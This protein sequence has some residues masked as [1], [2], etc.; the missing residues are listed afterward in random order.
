MIKKASRYNININIQ[1]SSSMSK[2]EKIEPQVACWT[3]GVNAGTTQAPKITEQQLGNRPF[4][5]G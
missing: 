5:W 3:V 1:M 4:T 2:A